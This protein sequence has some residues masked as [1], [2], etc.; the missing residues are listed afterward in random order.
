MAEM[1]MNEQGGATR[2]KFL[3][4]TASGPLLGEAATSAQTPGPGAL[5][6]PPSEFRVWLEGI[7]IPVTHAAARL[8]FAE[9][10]LQKSCDLTIEVSNPDFWERGVEV[11][12]SKHGIV[13]HVDG[14]RLTIRI[15]SPM[16]LVVRRPGDSGAL[17]QQL[18]LFAAKPFS[19]SAARHTRHFPPGV[20]R[21][22]IIARS[23]DRILIERGAIIYGAINLDGVHDV[24]IEGRGTIIYDGPQTPSQ[25]QGWQS[26]PN[27]HALWMRNASDVHVSGITLVVRSRTW[28]MQINESRHIILSDIRC[29]GG[30]TFNA[31]Q[32]GVDI[33]GSEDIRISDCFIKASDDVIAIYGNNRFYD[34]AVSAPGRAVRRV[35][36]ETSVLCT[37]VS[38]VM[39]VSWPKKVFDSSDVTVRDCDIVY[40]GDGDCVIPF[41][42]AEFWSEGGGSGLH[43]NYLFDRLRVE[44]AYSLLQIRQPAAAGEARV[45]KVVFRDVHMLGGPPTVGSVISGNADRVRLE[46]L[47]VGGVQVR[48][49]VDADRLLGLH[50]DLADIVPD[51]ISIQIRYSAGLLRSN[52]PVTFE[53]TGADRLACRWRFG[54]G[55]TQS[56]TTV[57]H[58]YEDMSGSLRD[59]TGLYLV[60]LRALDAQ[61]GERILRVPVQLGVK[62]QPPTAATTSLGP[63]R[64]GSTSIILEAPVDGGY[65]FTLSATGGAKLVV[66]DRQV[67]ALTPGGPLAC[68][69]PG[70]VTQV[71]RAGVT[72][73]A[74]RHVA[75]LE[76]GVNAS[77]APH[78]F[79][80]GPGISLQRL[81]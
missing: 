16:K 24:R 18:F 7:E 54:D 50:S 20:Y 68:G 19:P 56:G 59:G 25:D 2:R 42:V 31:N 62:L 58:R 41:A 1:V 13:P 26:R 4:L 78:L 64:P 33:V 46:R 43:R 32:D 73:A 12:P 36:I 53:V 57:V 81:Q 5:Q 34:Q 71:M 10:D 35:M 38:N 3:A 39:R 60:E 61:G 67:G 55:G 9:F 65:L 30:S 74:G 70:A 6:E 77:R 80:E 27:W 51:A 21:E 28:M 76:Y 17:P 15:D 52:D 49:D 23:G 47:T 44:S 72:L 11:L 29:I 66:G 37:S 14:A 40:M 48:S 45:E 8:S 22:D 69:T 63:A 79:W 75:Q